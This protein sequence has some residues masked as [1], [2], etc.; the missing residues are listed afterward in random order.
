MST[1][2]GTASEKEARKH[3]FSWI[4]S[5]TLTVAKPGSTTANISTNGYIKMKDGTYLIPNTNRA[6]NLPDKGLFLTISVKADNI[7][8]SGG[9]PRGWRVNRSGGLEEIVNG[10]LGIS[11]QQRWFPKNGN[12]GGG[13]RTDPGDDNRRYDGETH[14][15]Y[16]INTFVKVLCNQLEEFGT[17]Y[18]GHGTKGNGG[19]GIVSRAPRAPRGEDVV[20][21]GTISFSFVI[22]PNY[23]VTPNLLQIIADLQV[24]ILKSN[25]KI[26]FENNS[27]IR[28]NEETIGIRNNIDTTSTDRLNTH[29]WNL[30][31]CT[32]EV[33]DAY[34]EVDYLIDGFQE[35]NAPIKYGSILSTNISL[36]SKYR[37]TSTRG[38]NADNSVLG[39]LDNTFYKFRHL[40]TM[41]QQ[42][43]F[44]YNFILPTAKLDNHYSSE[45]N[46]PPAT[47]V[48]T[49]LVGNDAHL[50]D[51]SQIEFPINL[52]V[53]S[54]Y[55]GSIL[56]KHGIGNIINDQ[57]SWRYNVGK[58]DEIELFNLENS[59]GNSVRNGTNHL[60]TFPPTDKQ[61]SQ[62]SQARVT[63]PQGSNK[64]WFVKQ[65][66][67]EAGN[68]YKF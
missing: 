50:I 9:A 39:F 54:N 36:T 45:E 22:V 64:D 32:F 58:E 61:L 56:G 16:V 62:R 19:F 25:L 14:Y 47:L 33:V 8:S 2:P 13:R 51:A 6:N 12:L 30:P 43:L 11:Y 28:A 23:Q 49:R 67:L 5:S 18:R 66:H 17:I 24:K 57:L 63:M 53:Y 40:Q 34:T 37:G 10:G 60:P 68:S 38:A 35:K 26:R 41:I 44:N 31:P 55:R 48:G 52:N 4:P 15:H 42:Y 20:K 29:R 65:E 59:D 1:I 3:L 7:S 46:K 21:T 27:E